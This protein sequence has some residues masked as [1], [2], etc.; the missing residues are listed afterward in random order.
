MS[1]SSETPSLPKNFDSA[2][3]DM[4]V[5][6]AFIGLLV[7]WSLTLIGPFIIVGLW[8][9]ILAVAL[10]PTFLWLRKIFGGRGT[11]AA[12]VVTIAMLVVV[13]GP[14]SLLSAGLLENLR[15]LAQQAQAGKIDIPPPPAG[16]NDWPIVGE[17][18]YEIWS[19][20][21][22]NLAEALEDLAPHLRAVGRFMLAAGAA[23]GLSL[24]QF[25][26]AVIIAGFLFVPTDYLAK[27]IRAFAR[28]VVGRRGDQFVDLA[29]ATIRNVSRGV[30]GVA[31][32][33]SLLI[34]VGLLMAGV[35][36]AG[37]IT[38]LALVLGVVQI[39]PG[40]LVL[41]A[42]IWVWSSLETMEALLFTA[43]MIPVTLLDNILKPIVMARGLSTPMPVI[44][45]GVISGTL[46]HGIIGLF[47]G[48]IVLA[49]AY[50]LMILWVNRDQGDPVREA[51]E[52][53]TGAA[54]DPT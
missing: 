10:H 49:V 33:Q 30:I 13:L 32:L 2:V 48:P 15:D 41:G 51:V 4:A 17:E 9:V 40:I 16:V 5:R 12:A 39:G 23:G 42:L 45:V 28:R 18:L 50:E 38:F 47:V 37:L 26:V 21:S 19:L 3:V 27:G 54:K 46:S 24:I 1:T 20:A 11:P 36:G 53:A 6:L 31:L 44:F 34:G 52:E 8:G 25:L 29:S 14:T 35:P 22:V 7:G 43:Y